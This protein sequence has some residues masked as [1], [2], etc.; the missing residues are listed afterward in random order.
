MEIEEEMD[1]NKTKFV[2]V[3]IMI[4]EYDENINHYYLYMENIQKMKKTRTI[5]LG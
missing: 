3:V 5:A 1:R 2:V 4:N